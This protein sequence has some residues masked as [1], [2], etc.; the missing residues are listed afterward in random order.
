M[1]LGDVLAKVQI[2]DMNVRFYTDLYINGGGSTETVKFISEEYDITS[3]PKSLL[4]AK[5]KKC[6]ITNELIKVYL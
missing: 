1:C 4:L 2:K 3:I 6:E 5:Y